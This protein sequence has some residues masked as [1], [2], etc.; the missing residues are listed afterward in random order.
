[1][2]IQIELTSKRKPSRALIMRTLGEY[3]TNGA[4]SM[5]LNWGENWI[6]IIQN[7]YDKV[8]IG[9]GWIKDI[10]GSDIAQELNRTRQEALDQFRD[11]LKDH[12]TISFIGGK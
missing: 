2:A 10:D 12:V 8:W 4:T 9:G 6:R 7:P 3:I 5:Q 11:F 1:M